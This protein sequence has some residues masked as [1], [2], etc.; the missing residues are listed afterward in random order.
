MERYNRYKNTSNK[1]IYATHNNT[2]VIIDKDAYIK[3]NQLSD[4]ESLDKSDYTIDSILEEHNISIDL[5]KWTGSFE[6]DGNMNDFSLSEYIKSIDNGVDEVKM[7]TV[8]GNGKMETLIPDEHYNKQRGLTEEAIKEAIK[9][10]VEDNVIRV[11]I[12]SDTEESK[13]ESK[14]IITEN[15]QLEKECYTKEDFNTKIILPTGVKVDDLIEILKIKHFLLFAAPPGTGK[16]TTAIALANTI[17]GET[18]SD[19]LKIVSFNQSTEYS[20]M[21]SGLRQNKDGLWSIENGVLKECCD[22]AYDDPDN[23]YIIIIDEIN[24]G[25]TEAILGEYITAMSQI[26]QPIVSNTGN[27]L[28]MPSNL[29]IIATMNTA[30]S[31]ITKLDTATRDRFAIFSMKAKEFNAREIK[32]EEIEPSLEEAINLVIEKILEINKILERDIFKRDENILGMRQ[33]YTDYD[34]IYGLSLVFKMCIKPQIEC[35]KQNLSDDAKGKID[36]IVQEVIYKL[37]EQM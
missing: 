16:T 31:S 7:E 35:A 25:N 10:V 26:G 22:T 18:N 20:D 9:S 1:T 28:I 37:D 5:D 34:T 17:L 19:R 36:K 11:K 21:V 32:G 24:R 3:V 12:Q 33:L 27:T 23:K 14:E 13:G 30:D 6:D 29:Y 15:I 2:V 8:L 4:N